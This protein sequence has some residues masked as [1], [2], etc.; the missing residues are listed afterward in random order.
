MHF[1]KLLIQAVY[2]Q[3]EEQTEPAPVLLL[4]LLLLKQYMSSYSFESLVFT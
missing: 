4:L 1:R 2:D 3:G